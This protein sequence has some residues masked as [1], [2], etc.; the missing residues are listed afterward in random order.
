MKHNNNLT[1]SFYA[2]VHATQLSPLVDWCPPKQ[3]S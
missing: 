2:T 1:N 3:K